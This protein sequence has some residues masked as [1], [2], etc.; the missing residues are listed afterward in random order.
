MKKIPFQ[1]KELIAKGT[2]YGY[3]F[4]TPLPAYDTPVTA[5]ENFFAMVHHQKPCWIPAY[6]DFCVINP[7]INIEN[8]V[9]RGIRAANAPAGNETLCDRDMFGIDWEYVAVVGGSI[10]KPGNPRLTDIN[11]WKEKIPF[12]DVRSWNWEEDA[13]MNHDYLNNDQPKWSWIYCGFFERLISFMDFEE[14]IIAMIDEEKK[15][16]V[17]E[18]F[19]ALCTVYEDIIIRL[20]KYYHVDVIYFHDDWG[21][22]RAPFFSLD[23]CREMLVPYIK[24]LCNC[25]HDHDMIFELHC[26]GNVEM[27]VP[28]MIEAGVDI[29]GGQMNANDFDMLREQYGDQIILGIGAPIAPDADEET[30]YQSAKAYVEKYTVDYEKK[31]VFLTGFIPHLKQREAF[32]VLS[33]KKFSE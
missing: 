3:T 6:D 12:P 2:H 13:R 11:E 19:N 32:Y 8:E 23:T 24:R 9:H 29:W 4:R 16:Q 27:L 10:V 20:H 33:R 31:P 5:R 26:C 25:C 1:K 14:A 7:R 15:D 30:A 21:A 22:Q 18:L 17:K 28:A